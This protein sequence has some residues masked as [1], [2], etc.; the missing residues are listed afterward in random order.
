MSMEL[1]LNEL[2]VQPLSEDKYAANDKMK[3]FAEAISEARK[4]NFKLIRS[5]LSS[6]EISLTED[7]TLFDWLQNKDVPTKYRNFLFG[8][9][10][11][12][13]IKDED[14]EVVDKYIEANYFFEDSESGI[15]KTACTGLASAYLYETLSISLLSAPVWNKTKLPI[16]IENEEETRIES[17]F[18]VSLKKS[19]EDEEIAEYVGNLGNVELVET[20]IAPKDKKIHL[21]DHHGKKE[22][23]ELAKQ[24]KNSPYV[25]EMRS[26]NWGGKK[27]IRKTHKDGVIEVLL[28][29]TSKGYALWVQTTGRNLRETKAIA[30]I[31]DD[32]YS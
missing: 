29:K 25:V 27:F 9:I 15:A 2:S 22:L 6:S 13:F 30:Q 4:K 12:P 11:Q 21:A 5:H 28:Y 32:R 7:Y 24:L 26:T 18:N 23:A 16:I 8:M 31:L 17:V 20:D 3:Q 10:T 14:E 19:F 1:L